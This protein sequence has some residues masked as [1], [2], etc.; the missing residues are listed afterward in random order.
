MAAILTTSG[1]IAIATA[2][3]GR[4]A[5]HMAWGSGDPSWGSS[6]PAPP[7][8]TTALVNEVARR[9]ATQ[10][11]YC[12]P[13]QNGSIVVPEGRYSISAT[14]TNQLYFKFQFEFTEGVGQ[15]IREQAVF[16]DTVAASGVPSGQYY[17]VP[18]EVQSPGTLL[19]VERR[20]PILREATTRQLFEFVVIF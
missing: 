1:R 3:K 11:E 12:T 15:T 17:L 4:S 13:D 10:V 2:I 6:P 7:A 18:A 9:K 14:P 8:G 20:T 16:I 19:V 5:H